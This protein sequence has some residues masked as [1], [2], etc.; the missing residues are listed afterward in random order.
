MVVALFV[1]VLSFLFVGNSFGSDGVTHEGVQNNLNTVWTCLAAFLVFFMQA[2]FAMVEAGFT[3][4]KNGI[5]IIMKNLMDF[6]VG[7]L[8]WFIVGFGLMFGANDNGLF[9]VSHF[10]GAEG[11]SWTFWLFQCVFA[12]TAATI[13][14]G[15]MAGR[16]KFNSYLL[17]SLVICGFIYPVGGHWAWASLFGKSEGWLEGLKF[18]DFAGSTVVHAC[19]G[20]LALAGA[21]ILGPRIGKYAEDGTSRKIPGHNIPLASLGVFILWFGWFGFNAGSTNAGDSSIGY[22]AA[23]TNLSAIAGA[24]SAMLTSYFKHKKPDVGMTLNGALAGLV[25]ITAGCANLS[26]NA[27]LLTGLFAGILV[28]F[29]I[30][31]ID[32]KLKV[33]DPVGAVSVHGVCGIFG[34][35]MAGLLNTPGTPGYVEGASVLS[36]LIGITAICSWA[37]FSGL[38]LFYLIKVTVGL[39]VSSDV[40]IKGLD[41][42]EHGSESYAGFQIFLA[43]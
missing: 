5:N 32:E 36:Q 17:Y 16:T 21:I 22:I 8:M 37:F 19:G 24:I 31:F 1:L 43:Q 35:V 12:G 39:R 23:T 34:T 25:A 27:A 26:M 2:G 41:V 11:I 20:A 4:A 30:D 3:R 14:S 28:V 42:S 33:D 29:S 40:E 38:G 18:V 9:G 15:A 7:T 6:S 13:V 10:G